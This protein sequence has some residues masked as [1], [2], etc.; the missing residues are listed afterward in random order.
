MY[1]VGVRQALGRPLI[2]MAQK[3]QA[4]PF[5]LLDFRTIFFEL[6]LSGAKEARKELLDQLTASE[7]G[8]KDYAASRTLF[9]LSESQPSGN[10]AVTDDQVLS[11]VYGTYERIVRES[12][13]TRD[14][15]EKLR[16]QIAALAET[17]QQAFAMQMMSG[18]LE[19]GMQNPD[20]L[21][22]FMSVVQAF[23]PEDNKP[24]PAPS[25]ASKQVMPKRNKGR[26]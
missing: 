5:D 20:K 24:S 12:E 16:L 8:T 23:Q 13:E 19:Q 26:R 22:K 14:T 15:L 17:Q 6:S 25:H 1:E 18:L 10:G 11:A 21:E 2:L 9:G 4:L 7:A 3:G